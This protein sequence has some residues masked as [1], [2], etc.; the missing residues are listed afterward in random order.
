MPNIPTYTS[1]VE[2]SA[3]GAQPRGR[4]PGPYAR[5]SAFDTSEPGMGQALQNV[6]RSIGQAGELVF[7]LDQEELERTRT[8]DVAATAAKFDPTLVKQDALANSKA[9]GSDIYDNLTAGYRKA[10]DDLVAGVE[11]NVT[12]QRLKTHFDQMWPHLQADARKEFFTAREG[13]ARQQADDT[14]N[15]S[16]NQ[17][18]SDPSVFPIALS[19]VRTAMDARGTDRFGRVFS[20]AQRQEMGKKAYGM[21]A[22]AMFDGQI[23]NAKTVQD[24]TSIEDA[25]KNGKAPDGMDWKAVFDPKRYDATMTA[26]ATR[27]QQIV[28]RAE[29]DAKAVLGSIE[30]RTNDLVV[31]P[32]DEF[33]KVGPVVAQG[34]SPADKYRFAR[35]ERDNTILQQDGASPLPVLRAKVEALRGI[36]NAA[37]GAAA[38]TGTAQGVADAI[39]MQESGGRATSATSVDGAVGGWQITPDTFK[40]YAKLGEDINNPADNEAVGRRIIADLHGKTGGDPARIAVGYFSGEGNVAPPGSQTPW[41]EDRK[42]GNGKSVSSYVMD[43]LRRMGVGSAEAA[44]LPNAQGVNQRVA[45]EDLQVYERMLNAAEKA[46]KSGDLLAFARTRGSHNIRPLDDTPESWAAR[47]NDVRAVAQYNGVP[48]ASVNPFLPEDMDRYKRVIETGKPEDIL[49]TMSRMQR[50]GSDVAEAAYKKLGDHAPVAAY[51]AGLDAFAGRRGVA[52]DVV[53]GMKL[54]G[55]NKDIRRLVPA[56]DKDFDNAFLQ[57]TSA[58]GQDALEGVEPKVRQQMMDAAKAH[59]FQTQVLTAGK[60]ELNQ[61]LFKQ[62]IDA[63]LGGGLG[64]VNGRMTVPPPGATT[65]QMQSALSKMTADDIRAT[66]VVRG[67]NGAWTNLPGYPHDASGRPVA[68]DEFRREAKLV[69]IGGGRYQVL[70]ADNRPA[71]VGVDG[72]GKPVPYIMQLPANVISSFSSRQLPPS[73]A[74]VIMREAGRADKANPQTDM[75]SRYKAYYPDLAAEIDADPQRFLREKAARLPLPNRPPQ[76]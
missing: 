2:A 10:Q 52:L 47:G 11:D 56:E 7:R 39:H 51:A 43:V 58:K 54:L 59:Y 69:A 19:N 18:R 63:V 73:E 35:L 60:R 65:D 5:A 72:G 12:R 1:R 8:A 27:K 3:P 23:S 33:R 21:L 53:R 26:V 36:V 67:A 41:K 76:D 57:Y 75:L 4:L 49:D 16:I 64:K 6:G 37:G 9:D 34:N 66:A 50:A 25:L 71:V 14:L 32:P 20:E 62:S 46:E 38:L 30:Q 68:E 22:D 45:F 55:D 44:V 28:T 31:V 15:T 24:I 29:A 42:D 61:D 40:R 13:F 17:V 48:V 74:A 70:L